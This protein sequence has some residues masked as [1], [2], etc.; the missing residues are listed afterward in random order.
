[1][2][3]QGVVTPSHNPWASL[4]VLVAK[5]DGTTCFC[6]DYWKLNAITKMDVHPLPQIDDSLD[7]L[8]DSCYFST[9]DLASG[10]WQVS[11]SEESQEKTA[12]VTWN[13]L[14]EFKVMPFRLCNAPATF[15]HLMENGE[16]TVWAVREKCLIYLD[17]IL[18]MGRTFE[19]HI[20]NLRMVFDC[21]LKAGL[22][23]KPGKCKLVRKQ[24]EYLG[25]VV[26]STGISADPAKVLAVQGF[27]QTH[28]TKGTL[29]LFMTYFVLQTL[30]SL[31][32]IYSSAFVQPHSQRGTV[33]VDRNM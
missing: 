26:S 21:L 13:G 4:V 31:L 33:S 5:K 17:D 12:F 14:Y 28:E 2:L 6:V 11:M 16:S 8:A 24:V 15:Q 3:K 32:F 10:Y 30:Y 1:M 25:Y 23:L 22:W 9:L 18:V 20:D 29:S 27:P 7:Q 19:E